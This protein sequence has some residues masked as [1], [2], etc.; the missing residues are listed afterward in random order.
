MIKNNFNLLKII[1]KNYANTFKK[2]YKANLKNK[3]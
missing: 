2:Y 1:L 3:K